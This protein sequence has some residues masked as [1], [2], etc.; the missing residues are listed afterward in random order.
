MDVLGFSVMFLIIFIAYA[1]LGYLL[2]GS[3]VER[4]GAFGT[5]T[6]TLLRTILGDFDYM[7]IDEVDRTLAPIFFLT[8]I[9]FVF[10]IL[11]NMFL[12]IITDT[13]AQVK[14]EIAVAP[15]EMQMSE[16]VKRQYYG[17]MKTLGLTRFIKPIKEQKIDY[18]VTMEEIRG[19]LRKCN[20]TDLEIEMFFSR[21]NIDP[22]STVGD[23]DLNQ[24]LAELDKKRLRDGM[25]FKLLTFSFVT[26]VVL[27]LFLFCAFV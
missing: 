10:F 23:F 15:D 8:F 11:L 19:A 24:V 22:T 16:F 27:L 1:E 3:Q 17:A 5:S 7:S 20:F 4:F 14:T 9:F 6:F 12:A 25:L 13:Y 21:F 26:F 18:N 2:F